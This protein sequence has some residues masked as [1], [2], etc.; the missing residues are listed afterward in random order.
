MDKNKQNIETD[1][2]NENPFADEF[3]SGEVVNRETEHPSNPFDTNVFD[4]KNVANKDPQEM[5]SDE[6]EPLE[7]DFDD[8]P[9]DL[10]REEE[11]K[12]NFGKDIIREMGLGDFIERDEQP[13]LR[14]KYKPEYGT[15]KTKIEDDFDRLRAAFK[16]YSEFPDISGENTQAIHDN[17]VPEERLEISRKRVEIMD[18]PELS[19]KDKDKRST[20]IVN[21]SDEGSI[22]YLEVFCNCG[23]RTVIKFE[24][25]DFEPSEAPEVQHQEGDSNLREGEYERKKSEIEREIEGIENEINKLESEIQEKTK[26]LDV[27]SDEL[28]DMVAARIDSSAKALLEE[29]DDEKESDKEV[30]DLERE[31]DRLDEETRQIDAGDEEIPQDATGD[32]ENEDTNEKN[33]DLKSDFLDNFDGEQAGEK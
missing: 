4:R 21:R 26:E 5:T 33:E 8:E 6:E 18:D 32:E 2:E 3:D 31:I 23:E 11:G 10:P 12:E 22:D 7:R 15:D 19:A 9:I 30:D 16:D 1:S 20:V 14:S 17:L 27:D 13:R 29:N 24:Y 25:G 28:D